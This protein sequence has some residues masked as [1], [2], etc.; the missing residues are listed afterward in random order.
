MFRDFGIHPTSATICSFMRVI[1]D[2]TGDWKAVAEITKCSE[3]STPMI[4]LNTI[5]HYLELAFL[6]KTGIPEFRFYLY[7]TKTE[8]EFF[9]SEYKNK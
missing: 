2:S 3:N 4:L 9:L 1:S 8:S 7:N 5:L 6:R